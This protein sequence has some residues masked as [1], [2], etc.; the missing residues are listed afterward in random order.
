M[1]VGQ[2]GTIIIKSLDRDDRD[3][4]AEGAWAL[5]VLLDHYDKLQVAD[6]AGVVRRRSRGLRR[7]LRRGARDAVRDARPGTR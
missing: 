4:A 1:R 7:V 3:V 6:A 5:K 2:I